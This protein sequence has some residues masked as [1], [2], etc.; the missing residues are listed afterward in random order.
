MLQLDVHLLLRIVFGQE[1]ARLRQEHVLHD[2]D[3]AAHIKYTLH[4][5]FHGEL[6][7]LFQA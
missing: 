2:G 7:H 1:V 4:A 3:H 5:H 6:V